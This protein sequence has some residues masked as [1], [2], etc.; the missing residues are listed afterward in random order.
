MPLAPGTRLGPYEVTSLL[1]AGGMGEVYRALD[2]RLSREV[3]VKVRPAGLAEGPA[4][5]A[6]F[7]QEARVVATLSHPNVLALY[8]FGEEEGLFYAVTELLDGDTLQAHLRE[9]AMPMRKALEYSSQIAAGLAS[10]HDKGIVHRD[11]KP[12]NVFI[13]GDG[14]VKVLDF[15]LAHWDEG[16][17]GADDL[18]TLDRH[19]IP[20]TVMGTLGYMS[21]EQARGQRADHRSDIFSFGAVLYEMISGQRAFVRD[22]GADSLSAILSHDPPEPSRLRSGVPPSLDRV[23]RRCLEK[24]PGERFQ[25][26][27][28][29]SFALEGLSDP[30]VSTSTDSARDENPSI[31][32]L[33]FAN[34]SPDPEQEYFCEGIAEEI[35]N[36]LTR[37]ENVR[38][39]SRTSAFQ[40]KGRSQ[41]MRKVG[42]G[43]N[44]KT[45]L[46]G[47][48]R[49]A[50]KRLRVTAQLVGVAD[51]STLWSERYDREM[52][53]VFAIQDDISASIVSALRGR[54]AAGDSPAPSRRPT[55]D[56]EAYQLYLKGQHN[57]FKRERGS[58]ERAAHFFE[59]AAERDPSFVAAL[60]GAANAYASLNLYGMEPGAAGATAH[61][62]VQRA[63]ALASDDA[64]VRTAL[65]IVGLCCDFDPVRSE[66][67]L[68]RAVTLNPSH[69][70]AQ[71]YLGFALACSGQGDEA[72]VAFRRAQELD[73][74]SPYV[75]AATGH[76]FLLGGRLP[77]A[78]NQFEKA[79]DID[80]DFLLSLFGLAGA[81]VALG[82]H[83]GGVSALERAAVL[84]GRSSFFLG[85]LGWAYGCAGRRADAEALLRELQERGT[86]EYVAPPF[87]GAIHAALGEV[88]Q[89]FEC[90]ERGFAERNAIMMWFKWPL[91][92]SL[93]TDSRYGELMKRLGLGSA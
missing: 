62:A 80:A 9:G 60:A 19:T 85:W 76:A 66:A 43:L 3:A 86:T 29:L 8:D 42:E 71:C 88:D 37:L 90:L 61:A 47:S 22:T 38:V 39:A 30:E 28:D 10:A 75:Q 36:A 46:E 53:D 59:R 93:R 2:S 40:F 79:K 6:R 49:T 64:E 14:R 92:T 57:W 84:A 74:L 7:K 24:K 78:E 45:V 18:S 26:A 50:G 55:E 54:W 69:V 70:I 23:V 56:L 12:A 17:E 21:P 15:G 20:G 51:G 16:A 72:L 4:A 89:A 32:V 77:E 13:T 73:P 82:H 68:R 91:Y 11:L 83:E 81:R 44:V 63:V 25:S 27:R 67:E 35:I 58:L 31:A 65:G 1:G 41:D 87:L 33:P 5:L 52:E 48:V 34:M